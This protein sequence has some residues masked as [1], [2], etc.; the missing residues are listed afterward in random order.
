MKKDERKKKEPKKS[1]VTM[2]PQNDTEN[3]A[4]KCHIGGKGRYLKVFEG[5]KNLQSSSE[6]CR[7]YCQSMYYHFVNRRL[8]RLS[9]KAC[10]ATFKFSVKSKKEKKKRER[11]SQ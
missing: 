8:E 5:K 6:K 7:E 9:C 10:H 1:H 3:K 4:T 2:S 11:R